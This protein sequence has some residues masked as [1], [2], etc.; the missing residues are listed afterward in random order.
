MDYKLNDYTD[1]EKEL[2]EELVSALND[3]NENGIDSSVSDGFNKTSKGK[4]SR[5]GGCCT[6]IIALTD[7][8]KEKIEK[9]IKDTNFKPYSVLSNP[10]EVDAN[11]GDDP[12]CPFLSLEDGTAKCAIYSMRPTTCRC[13]K[14]DLE[15]HEIAKAISDNDIKKNKKYERRTYINMR[16]IFFNQLPTQPDERN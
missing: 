1:V 7:N 4:C 13:F 6:N 14:C 12:T 11:P 15:D 16:A 9:W 5:C 10:L 8:E 3:M 2:F